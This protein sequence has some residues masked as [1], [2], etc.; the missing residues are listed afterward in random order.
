V[1][2]DSSLELAIALRTSIKQMQI[3][4]ADQIVVEGGIGRKAL[5]CTDYR[6]YSYEGAMLT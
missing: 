6:V 5:D 3:G 4:E 2:V 1:G